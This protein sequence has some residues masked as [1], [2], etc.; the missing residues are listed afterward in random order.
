MA[1]DEL[2]PLHD[3]N[4]LIIMHEMYN[5]M[6]QTQGGTAH[7][8]P[9]KQASVV[10]D[11]MKTSESKYSVD[12]SFK[13]VF[14]GHKYPA[15]QVANGGVSGGSP[16]TAD[17]SRFNVSKIKQYAP[18]PPSFKNSSLERQHPSNK[19][20]QP[21]PQQVRQLRNRTDTLQLYPFSDKRQ[22]ALLELDTVQ[23]TELTGDV[24]KQKNQG[25]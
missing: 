5:R 24:L 23:L 14:I 3:T 17:R 22:S 13:N 2:A 9:T 20:V 1:L 19:N 12:N 11:E 15:N 7:P 6:P 25:Q 18:A 8:T 16:H 10:Q 21:A 4:L